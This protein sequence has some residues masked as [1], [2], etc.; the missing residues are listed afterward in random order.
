[1]SGCGDWVLCLL[2]FDDRTT[3]DRP[4]GLGVRF[5]RVG[6]VRKTGSRVPIFV[7]PKKRER[8]EEVILLYFWISFDRSSF[9]SLHY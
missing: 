4:P 9:G 7:L 3:V 5:S 8:E 1:M 6:V 2:F